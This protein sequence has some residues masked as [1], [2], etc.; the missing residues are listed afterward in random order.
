[1]LPALTTLTNVVINLKRFTAP[2][3]LH[4][5]KQYIGLFEASNAIAEPLVSQFEA[6]D[7][8]LPIEIV[9]GARD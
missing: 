5:S 9:L 6:G 7:E 2:T 3:L 8:R 1:M 4:F